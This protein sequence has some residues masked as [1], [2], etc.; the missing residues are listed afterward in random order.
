MA[1]TVTTQ[2]YDGARNVVVHLNNFSD[3][4]GET[5]VT[6]V[7]VANLNPNPTT[8]LVLWRCSYDIKGGGVELYWDAT[9]DKLLLSMSG[10]MTDRDFS[11]WGGLRNDAGAGITGDVQLTTTGFMPNSGYSITLEFKKGGIF[12]QNV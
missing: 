4:T 2:L 3:G 9:A 5:A 6:K 12:G 8:H 7:T 11:R 1:D 10:Q